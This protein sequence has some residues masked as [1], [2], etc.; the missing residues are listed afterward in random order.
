MPRAPK[1]RPNSAPARRRGRPRGSAPY[2]QRDEELLARYA[3]K[4]IHDPGLQLAP[5][6]R[7][8]GFSDA[9]IRRL[10][11]RWREHRDRFLNEA[12]IRFDVRPPESLWQ[13]LLVLWTGLH[14]GTEIV[15]QHVLHP[16]LTSVRRAERRWEARAALDQPA[17]LPIDPTNPG[18][19]EPA[20][21]R[22]EDALGSADI[23][24][25]LAGKTLGDLPL[26]LRL[27]IMAVLMHEVS[28]DQRRREVEASQPPKGSADGERT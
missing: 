2:R 7:R 24:A 23:A 25:Q 1:N 4:M 28:L 10:Q 21:A 11:G 12:R 20:F 16:L 9:A 14:R 8:A 19:L 22:F 27:Y 13:I 3:D 18:E 6:A 15:S 5:F 17:R 26:S